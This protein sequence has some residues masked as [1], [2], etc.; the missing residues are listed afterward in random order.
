MYQA[1]YQRQ[2]YKQTAVETANPG[3]I[4]ITLYDAAIR[5]L[6]LGVQQINENNV[7]AKGVS[8]SRAY[9]IISEFIHA[10]DH[11]KAPELCR[12]LES[13]YNFM[14]EQ[15]GDAN[16]QMSAAPIGPVLDYMVDLR[17]TWS[18]AVA[19]AA[20]ETRVGNGNGLGGAM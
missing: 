17:E 5:F 18:Q 6:R 14:L 7:A 15:I 16:T 19:I 4:L 20:K 1:T 12:N 11:S 3:R 2:L 8:L 10:L 13:I 9:A